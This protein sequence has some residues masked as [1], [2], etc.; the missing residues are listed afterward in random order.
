ML[1]ADVEA[2]REQ[3]ARLLRDGQIIAF[4]TETVYGLGARADR[5]DVVRMLYRI[6]NRP[7]DKKFSL[8][9]PTADALDRYGRPD[10]AARR[11]AEQFW[12]GPL[13]MVVPDGQGGDVG[14]RCPDYEPT[15]DILSRADMPVAAPSANPTAAPP[16]CSAQEVMAA[17]KG[18]IAAIVDGGVARIGTPSTVVRLTGA[19]LEILRTGSLDVG[20]L[21]EV[22]GG[23]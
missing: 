9:V 2:D 15:R 7:T 19:K 17:F 4:P 13:T 1:Q 16:A 21:R 8:L 10:A 14:L 22:F 3:A 6:K 12:P 5:P 11:L 20:R 23:S 18:R